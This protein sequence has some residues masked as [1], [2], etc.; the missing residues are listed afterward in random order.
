MMIISITVAAMLVYI[1]FVLWVQRL[2]Q[3]LLMPDET[4]RTCYAA[5]CGDRDAQQCIDVHVLDGLVP[6]DGRTYEDWLAA[7]R[8]RIEVRRG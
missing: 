6:V 2:D 3:R 8:D 7:N 1:G 5:M 4:A